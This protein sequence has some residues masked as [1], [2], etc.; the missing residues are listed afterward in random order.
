MAN[1]RE[2]KTKEREEERE[3]ASRELRLTIVLCAIMGF[4]PFAVQ[5]DVLPNYHHLCLDMANGATYDDSGVLNRDC[6]PIA[7]EQYYHKQDGPGLNELHITT[8]LLQPNGAAYES[9][10][11]SGTFYI[12]NT[13]SRGYADE[14]I[15]LVSINVS[16]IPSDFSLHIQSSGYEITTN[17][18]QQIVV[19]AFKPDALDQT[20]TTQ[21][22]TDYGYGPQTWRPAST[23]LF[24]LWY[25]QDPNTSSTSSLLLFID[26]NVASVKADKIVGATYDGAARVDFTF[27]GLPGLA[28]FNVYGFTFY[29][30]QGQGISWTN[31]TSST[32]ATPSG[33]TV[34]PSEPG[35]DVPAA[36]AAAIPGADTNGSHAAN[37][38][39]MILVPAVL[40]TV[41]KVSLGL[42]RKRT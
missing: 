30:N 1:H 32:S 39:F 38:L 8:D 12:T 16:S 9:D 34:N 42:V 33:Y 22:F 14:V 25:G 24:P 3:M 37:V 27:T 36:E 41:G 2:K 10:D 15:L 23:A 31:D 35:W 13:G 7:N 4:A 28:A 20:F 40:V 29:S 5:A 26:L 21:D 18:S 17:S 11:Q 6:D 19:Y